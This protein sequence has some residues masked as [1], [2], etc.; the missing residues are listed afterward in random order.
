[1][2]IIFY[3]VLKHLPLFKKVFNMSAEFIVAVLFAVCIALGINLMF[4]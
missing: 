1:M 4:S 2:Y 3:I